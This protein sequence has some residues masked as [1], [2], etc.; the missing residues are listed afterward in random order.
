MVH[1]VDDI[2]GIVVAFMVIL[3]VSRMSSVVNLVSRIRRALGGRAWAKERS[4]E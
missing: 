3:T 2:V 4:Q 1:P